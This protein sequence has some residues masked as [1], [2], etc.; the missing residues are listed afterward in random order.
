MVKVFNKVLNII[1]IFIILQFFGTLLT[2]SVYAKNET[3]NEA[4]SE[5]FLEQIF[6]DG[7]EAES[8]VANDVSNM[9]E[10]MK[11]INS[12][13]EEI[14]NSIRLL[15]AAVCLVAFLVIII[16]LN[17][18]KVALDKARIKMV[19]GVVIFLAILYI[20]AG[21]I[22]NKVRELLESLKSI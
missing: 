8:L 1:I 13:F 19:L 20:F 4:E 18:G 7:K 14:I 6:S 22:F 17:T 10:S 12:A 2:N 11:P 5:S 3:K 9:T 21:P 16:G 15:G